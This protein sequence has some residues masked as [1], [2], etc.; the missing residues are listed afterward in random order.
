MKTKIL[1]VV[2]LTLLLNVLFVLPAMSQYKPPANQK[3]PSEHTKSG[4]VRGC[5]E[6][7]IPLTILSPT[8][9]VGQTVSR[10]PT[11]A[12]FV[13]SSYKVRFWLFEFQAD[14]K[15]KQI[16]EKI[17]L[18]ASKGINKYSLPENHP[19]LT[20][21]KKYLWQVSMSC[22]DMPMPLIKSS[23][24][25]VVEVPSSINSKL[26]T[27]KDSNQKAIFYAEQGFWYDA[28]GEALKLRQ[29]RKLGKLGSNL[30]LSLALSEEKGATSN[31]VEIIENLK[32]IANQEK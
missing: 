11:F 25:T 15:L 3:P 26:L 30:L 6:E 14:D 2:K 9:Y 16:G 24:F 28:F 20:V 8:T 18:Q 22:P 17:E 5:P 19:E 32:V 10:R 23:E 21:G 7:Q 27:T 31:E 4:G 29:E 12:W 13:N 1:S